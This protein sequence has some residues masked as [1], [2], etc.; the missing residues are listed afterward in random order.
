MKTKARKAYEKQMPCSE[1]LIRREIS[2]AKRGIKYSKL[3][4][5][6]YKGALRS[7][8]TFTSEDVKYVEKCIARCLKTIKG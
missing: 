4:L 6:R 8:H 7:D 5:S 2:R 1:M 3:W